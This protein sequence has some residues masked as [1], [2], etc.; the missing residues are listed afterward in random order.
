MDGG[1]TDSSLEIIKKWEPK[2]TGWY[3]HPDR[4]QAAAINEGIAKGSAPFVCWLNSDDYFYPGGLENLLRILKEKP[5][6]PFAYGKCWTV[7]K[8]GKKLSRY[9]TQSFSPW[10][11]ANFCF[12]AQPATLI[13]RSAW[14][15]A[16]G[17]NEDMEMAFDYDLWWRLYNTFGKPEYC[18]DFIAATRM[19]KDTKTANQLELHYQESI[20]VVRRHNGSVPLKWHVALPVMKLIRKFNK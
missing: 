20:D 17:V 1:S 15:K 2:L 14:E 5:E 6:Q 18:K 8:T 3:S 12:I 10:L 4:G 7:S 19:H 13:R 11:F 16:K 9:L